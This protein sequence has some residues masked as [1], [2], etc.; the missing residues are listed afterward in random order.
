[1][2]APIKRKI[3]NNKGY[4]ISP[5]YKKLKAHLSSYFTNINNLERAAD[6]RSK[7]EGAFLKKVNEIIRVNLG[8]ESFDTASLSKAM[9][10]SRSQLFRRLKSLTRMAPSRYIHYVR[11]QKAKEFLEKEDFTVGEAAFRTGFINQSHFTRAFREQFGFNP[12]ELRQKQ[13]DKAK[14]ANDTASFVTKL[15]A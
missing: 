13:K 11:L 3:K 14:L 9:Y 8:D 12:S 10:L 15:N 6:E 2:T 1:M 4:I 5:F 7:K